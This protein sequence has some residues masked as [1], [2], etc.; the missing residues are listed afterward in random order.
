LR[1]DLKPGRYRLRVAAESSLLRKS[2]SV[3]T[4][5][6]VPDFTKDGVTLS[7][8]VMS[9]TP[10]APSAPKDG[11][12]DL[13]PVTP[14]SERLF[15]RD[16]KVT[17]MLRL[18]QGGKKPLVPVTLVLRVVDARNATV[19]EDMAALGPERFS[20]GRLADYLVNLPV[21]T[22]RTG[23]YLLTVEA[24]PATGQRPGTVAIR[25]DVQFSVR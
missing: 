2:G 4:D 23:R 21:A 9:V 3:Y 12:R 25:R 11:L 6:D 13:L 19:F 15:A 18:C 22:L 1:I 5:V 8:L 24:A 10:G 20:T 17:A 7:G 14:T 16:D